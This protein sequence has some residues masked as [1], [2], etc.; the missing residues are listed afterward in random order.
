MIFDE[1]SRNI[2]RRFQ[3]P[4]GG[5]C[6][7]VGRPSV[8]RIARDLN[9]HPKVVRLRLKELFDSGLIRGV[10]FYT[11]DAFMPWKRYFV[12]I[13]KTRGV[14]KIIYDHFKEFPFIE[15][16]IFGTLYVSDS[17]NFPD[18]DTVEVEFSSIA[19]IA[20]ND[21]DLKEK[22]K[23]VEA[24][25]GT[26]PNIIGVLDDSSKDPKLL[27]KIDLTIVNEILYQDPLTMS[28]NDMAQ[29]LNIPVHTL[30]RRIQKLL[31]DEVIYEE[32]S[33]DTNKAKGVLIASVIIKGDYH[34][35]LPKILKSKFLSE[36]LL[37]YKNF[38]IFSFFIFYAENF[39]A[40]DDLTTE[41]TKIE[42]G[43]LVTYRNGSYNNPYVTYPVPD[44]ML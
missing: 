26:E 7:Y 21:T 14:Q 6:K 37:L 40:I 42:P 4:R 15:R 39:S 23:A 38:S 35:W 18:A 34:D 31:D 1:I 29:K 22:M 36:R 5:D 8:Y 41:V 19:I 20:M 33:L 3:W 10:K 32:V 16:V 30:R 2:L 13:N 27:N 12:L 25:F 43:S 28:I 11:D 9:V 17:S 44:T 24:I